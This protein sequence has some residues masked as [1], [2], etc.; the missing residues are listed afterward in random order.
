MKHLALIILLLTYSFPILAEKRFALVIGNAQYENSPLKN[1]ENDS[2]SI[3]SALCEIGFETYLIK[4]ANRQEMM[5]GIKKFSKKGKK[6]DVLL[7]FYAGHGIEQDGINYIIPVNT[8]VMSE[9][10]LPSAAVSLDYV[11]SQIS[12]ASAKVNLIFLDS[13]R[14]NSLVKGSKNLFRGLT[15]VQNP[16]SIDSFIMFATAP[17][18]VA[19]D[20][21]GEH[22]PFTESLLTYLQEP[23]TEIE[24]LAKK[25]RQDVR[26]KT[27]NAQDPWTTSNLSRSFFFVPQNSDKQ[28]NEI[29]RENDEDETIFEENNISE[30]LLL[31]GK[32]LILISVNA[33]IFKLIIMLYKR[34]RKMV[35]I[36]NSGKSFYIYCRPVTYKDWN[37]LAGWR[38]GVEQDNYPV[39]RVNWY[40]AIM[41]CN[42]LSQKEGKEPYYYVHGHSV[43]VQK[44][45]DGYRLPTEKEWIIAAEND[46]PSDKNCWYA[47][48]SNGKTHIAKKKAYSKNGLFDM[49]GNIYEWCFDDIGNEK[50][51]KGGC[52]SSSLTECAASARRTVAPDMQSKKIGF[53]VVR[54]A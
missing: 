17:G 49:Y 9:E 36:K 54:N 14:T 2:D 15:V 12:Y 18:R 22:S 32:V 53:R 39:T 48:N 19:D 34:C 13:C 50:V 3:A 42:K 28:N 44:D 38:T 11:L 31:T 23:E 37:S 35:R 20:G 8:G 5:A 6:A 43:I 29:K 27:K 26:K 47:N 40:E 45:A 33:G 30:K 41:Y 1:P 21:K 25:I 51:I 7:I 4:N 10:S 46:S 24:Q 16:P 52:F